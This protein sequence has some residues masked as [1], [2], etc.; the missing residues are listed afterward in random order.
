ML[1][2]ASDDWRSGRR[3]AARAEIV[4]VAKE[5]ASEH[6][7]AGL[8]LR[9]LARRLG[10][11]APSLYSYFESKMALYDAM[12]A[13]G[14]RDLLVIDRPQE[15][16]ARRQIAALARIFLEFSLA[17]P[18]RHQLLFQRTIPGFEPSPESYALAVEAY[19]PLEQLL[20]YDGVVAEDL[21]LFTALFT[22]LADQ[23]LSNDPGGDRWVRLLDDAVDM[24]A[25]RIEARS[26]RAASRRRGAAR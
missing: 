18:V 26:G 20:D 5:V 12:F 8:S 7:L 13:A 16:D 10:M 15:P 19:R 14:Y 23:Q 4:R 1:E 9:D 25:S 3:E 21:D 17:D 22:G 6:G 11:A 24:L 2:R